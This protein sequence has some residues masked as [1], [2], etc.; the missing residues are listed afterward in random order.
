M[1]VLLAISAGMMFT[2]AIVL[3]VYLIDKAADGSKAAMV[4]LFLFV[5]CL[6]AVLFI[7]A[8]KRDDERPCVEYKTVMQYNV[9]VK[10]MMPVRYCAQYGEWVDGSED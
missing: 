10:M 8:T 9:A 5:S 4:A 3:C 2:G 7:A 6:S 1:N